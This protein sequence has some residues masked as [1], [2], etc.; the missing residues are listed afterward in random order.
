[1]RALAFRSEKK[2]ILS[3]TIAIPMTKTKIRKKILAFENVSNTTPTANPMI[4]A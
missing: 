4:A 1:V 2:H 3:V